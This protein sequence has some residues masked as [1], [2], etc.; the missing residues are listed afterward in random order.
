MRIKR[1]WFDLEYCKL[2]YGDE[3]KRNV[4]TQDRGSYAAP[5]SRET[6]N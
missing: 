2:Q 1:V 5:R 4:E 6:A 3:E